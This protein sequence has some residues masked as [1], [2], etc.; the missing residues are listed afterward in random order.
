MHVAPRENVRFFGHTAKRTKILNSIAFQL[1]SKSFINAKTFYNNSFNGLNLIDFYIDKALNSL[2]KEDNNSSS[3]E[4]L[5]TETDI[6][7]K[8]SEIGS[9]LFKGKVLIVSSKKIGGLGNRVDK[10]TNQPY[11][12]LFCVDVSETGELKRPLLFSRI[13]NTKG[14]EGQVTFTEDENTLYFTRSTRENSK[15]YQLYKTNLEENSVGNGPS[16]TLVV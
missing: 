16:P 4:F 7:T 2:E 5:I 11:T 10:N 1:I 6:N 3:S 13:L 14:N 9:G 15:N 8:Y 12:D